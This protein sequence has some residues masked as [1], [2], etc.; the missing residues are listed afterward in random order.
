MATP[1]NALGTGGGGDQ[2]PR[3]QRSLSMND[4]QP[5]TTGQQAEIW[6]A[7]TLIHQQMVLRAQQVKEEERARQLKAQSEAKIGA[8]RSYKAYLEN[9]RRRRAAATVIQSMVRGQAARQEFLAQREAAI[10][11]QSQVRG[12]LARR[13]YERQQ[14]AALVLQSAA[15][16]ASAR[17]ELDAL[18]KQRDDAFADLDN[19][20]GADLLK[21]GGVETRAAAALPCD[22]RL[23]TI[24]STAAANA[25]GEMAE[26]QS[27]KN[28]AGYANKLADIERRFKVAIKDLRQRLENSKVFVASLRELSAKLVLVDDTNP[29]DLNKM[30]AALSL[31]NVATA[32]G[33]LVD[34]ISAPD[35]NVGEFY[36]C[37]EQ[38]KKF[39]KPTVVSTKPKK[40][41][42][43]ENP[44]TWQ[45][46]AVKWHTRVGAWK[47]TMEGLKDGTKVL[48]KLADGSLTG[49][50][51]TKGSVMKTDFVMHEHIGSGSNGIGFCYRH[52]KDDT[53][54]PWVLDYATGRDGNTYEWT[55]GKRDG[56]PNVALPA[57]ND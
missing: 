29:N 30:I 26:I 54:T 11:L 12:F 53:V 50:T 25:R 9:G 34:L 17:R 42:D 47:T 57:Q 51:I 31:S 4:A 28:W 35:Q 14:Q 18:V 2:P 38:I 39:Y 56:D 36:T 48:G 52:E 22:K 21:W 19:A 55:S 5:F 32:W 10:T 8:A 37:L 7:F 15:R 1:V 6:D 46:N 41:Y 24:A 23:G 49:R 40:A 45:L 20:I 27:T 43:R 33:T 16:G 3:R 13:E 44:N